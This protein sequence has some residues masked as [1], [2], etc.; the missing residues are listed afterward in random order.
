MKTSTNIY[1]YVAIASCVAAVAGIYG[2]IGIGNMRKA[3]NYLYK[4]VTVPMS[5]LLRVAA[6]YPKMALEARDAI[7]AEMTPRNR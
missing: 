7:L 4:G 5:E 3:D 2:L 6:D 1:A